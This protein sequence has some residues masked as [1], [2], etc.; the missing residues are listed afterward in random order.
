MAKASSYLF[1]IAS[2]PQE[3]EQIFRL[4]HETFAEEIPQHDKNSKG[5]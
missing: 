3:F 1:K 2:H 4:N 5:C